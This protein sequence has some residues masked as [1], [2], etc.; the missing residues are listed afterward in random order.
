MEFHNSPLTTSTRLNRNS[1]TSRNSRNVNPVISAYP[2]S[3][4]LTPLPPI[5]PGMNVPTSRFLNTTSLPV[6]TA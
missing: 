2:F 1:G 4:I 5:I 6:F 3:S